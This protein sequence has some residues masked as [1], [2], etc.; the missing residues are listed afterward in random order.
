MK[1]IHLMAVETEPDLAVLDRLSASLAG[2]FGI[3]CRV[4]DTVIDPA[5]ALDPA[6]NQYHSTAILQAMQPLVRK[7]GTHLLAVT[8][9]DLYVP[10]LTFVFGEAQ[11]SG[12][13]ALVSTHRLRE[14]FYGLPPREPLFNDRLVKEAVHELGHTFGLRHCPDW[15]CA[16]ASTHSVE[17]LDLKAARFCERCW[18]IVRKP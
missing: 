13:C 3:S 1:A 8:P 4:L 15:R 5:F 12:P 14:E 9:V 17:R 2:V 11:L 7:P 10:I 18:Q 16:M 6:R